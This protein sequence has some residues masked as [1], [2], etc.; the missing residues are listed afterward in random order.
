MTGSVLS[1]A[2]WEHAS[3]QA[4]RASTSRQREGCRPCWGRGLNR[5]VAQETPK[6]RTQGSLH[7][8]PLAVFDNQAGSNPA[9]EPRIFCAEQ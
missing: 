6:G 4:T 1:A 5:R 3:S 7:Q 2:W 9:R 8:Y